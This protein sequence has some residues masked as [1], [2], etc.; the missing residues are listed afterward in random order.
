[1]YHRELTETEKTLVTRYRRDPSAAYDMS[2]DEIHVVM[3]VVGEEECIV[4]ALLVVTGGTDADRAS[5]LGM[6]L[7]EWRSY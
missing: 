5:A 2:A 7:E 6:D 3:G 4:D 1:M